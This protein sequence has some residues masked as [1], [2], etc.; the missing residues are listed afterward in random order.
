M[1][2]QINALVVPFDSGARGLRMGA[3]PARLVKSGIFDDLR[4][5]VSIIEFEPAGPEPHGEVAS[6]FE[7][8]RWLAARV[9]ASR[10]DGAFPFVIAGNCMASVG[11]FAGLRSRSRRVPGVCWFDAHADFNTPETTPSGFLDGMAVATLTGR[12]WTQLTGSIPHFRPAPEES[13]L[14][15]GTRDIDKAERAALQRSA[16]QWPKRPSEN[17]LDDEQLAELRT[18]FGE[19]YLH[20]DFDVLDEAEARANQFARP[21]GLTRLQLVD[22][23]RTIGASFHIGAASFTAYDPSFDARNAMPPIARELV[24]VIVASLA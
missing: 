12:C 17:A 14:M 16:I 13:V 6:A 19:V 24:E 3:G 7:I 23:V 10:A 9:S 5:P 15:F 18:R 2:P 11:V 20:I 21:G 1:S 8:A 22:L 4:R